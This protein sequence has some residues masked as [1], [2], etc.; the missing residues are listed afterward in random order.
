MNN[1]IFE[2][3]KKLELN[4][5]QFAELTGISPSR[6]TQL[7][8]R[9][10]SELSP[11]MLNKIISSVKEKKNKNVS[12][13]WLFFGEGQMFQQISNFKSDKLFGFEE[14]NSLTT[15]NYTQDTEQKNILENSEIRNFAP[16]KTDSIENTPKNVSEPIKIVEK[17]IETIIE[18]PIDKKI[19]EIIVFYDNGTFEKIL[20]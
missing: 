17:V 11:S 8:Q 3:I 13:D 10:S 15:D 5:Q 19:K 18:K 9:S 7:R 20:I 16:K 2:L 4:N 1:R 6:L 12:R 14:E